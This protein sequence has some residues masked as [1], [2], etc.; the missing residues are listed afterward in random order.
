MP[1][2]CSICL[3][4]VPRNELYVSPCSIPSNTETPTPP[5]HC[6]HQRCVRKYVVHSLKRDFQIVK[7]EVRCVG[8]GAVRCP[9][10]RQGNLCA[11][12][13]TSAGI[14]AFLIDQSASLVPLLDIAED[15]RSTPKIR[16]VLCSVVVG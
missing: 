8:G 14:Q 9:N 5:P 3:E 16:D 13:R 2:F 10:C 1:P 4:D 6:F 11:F 15:G 7:H 12:F